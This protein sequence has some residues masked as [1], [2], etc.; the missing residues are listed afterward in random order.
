[1]RTICVPFD[2]RVRTDHLVNGHCWRTNNLNIIIIILI[3]WS[4]L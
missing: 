4:G 3:V 2:D 1:V